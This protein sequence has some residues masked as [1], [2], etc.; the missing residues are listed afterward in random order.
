[1]SMLTSFNSTIFQQKNVLTQL[2]NVH[3]K[4]KH[5]SN[6]YFFH[7]IFQEMSHLMHG[8]NSLSLIN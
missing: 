3:M 7:V 5:I 2:T 4:N 8:I 1:M 6:T